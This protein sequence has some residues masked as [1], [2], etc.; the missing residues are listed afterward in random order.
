MQTKDWIE[1]AIMLV[2]FGGFYPMLKS[3]WKKQSR[4]HLLMDIKLDSIIHAVFISANGSGEKARM[5]Y[6][7]KK[8]ELMEEHDFTS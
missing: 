8:K 5:A 4:T 7:Q 6:E 2:G 3:H 1:I